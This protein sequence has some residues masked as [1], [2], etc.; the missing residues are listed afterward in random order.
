MTGLEYE[1]LHHIYQVGKVPLSYVDALSADQKVTFDE[2]QRKGWIAQTDQTGMYLGV[3]S[4][5]SY[6]LSSGGRLALLA[7]KER[8]EEIEKAIVNRREEVKQD[9]KRR[10]KDA[11]RSWWQIIIPTAVG[12]VLRELQEKLEEGTLQELFQSFFH[13]LS[14]FWQ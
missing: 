8:K 13:W 6:C 3:P 5:A 10:A 1:I 4:F 12:Y 14:S 2:M 7:E 11:R 9:N